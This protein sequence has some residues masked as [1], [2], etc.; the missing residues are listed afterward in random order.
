MRSL[1][2]FRKDDAA[3][4]PFQELHAKVA[5]DHLNLHA[6]SRLRHDES[7]SRGAE[8]LALNDGA[9]DFEVSQVHGSPRVI[10][11]QDTTRAARS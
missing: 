3:A 5:L 7:F 6:N 10:S 1:P 11:Q 8:A 2:G 4:T 9:E